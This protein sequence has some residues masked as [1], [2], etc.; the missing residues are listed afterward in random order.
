MTVIRVLPQKKGDSVQKIK[1]MLA[2]SKI[3]Y[4]L[5]RVENVSNS[6]TK[7]K[8]LFELLLFNCPTESVNRILSNCNKEGELVFAQAFLNLVLKDSEFFSSNRIQNFTNF[9]STKLS[10][11]D[12][13]I[14]NTFKG[15]LDL[16]S[17]ES[18]IL[19]FKNL[20]HSILA[21]CWLSAEGINRL[22]F[23][24]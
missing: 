20:E 6:K 7:N 23:K 17:K 21:Y 2:E 13:T 10:S 4:E 18:I 19:K 16:T 1:S 11:C 22:Q 8:Y 9:M 24:M 14:S 3:L 5:C 12:Y 15:T